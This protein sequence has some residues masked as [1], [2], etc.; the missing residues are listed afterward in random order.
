MDKISGRKV[1][2]EGDCFIVIVSE[3][4]RKKMYT[5]SYE[6]NRQFRGYII[7]AMIKRLKLALK[8]L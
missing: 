3:D 1:I 7:M 2:K 8:K 6:L 4:A 5:C